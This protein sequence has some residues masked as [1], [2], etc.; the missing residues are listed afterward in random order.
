[1]TKQT[2]LRKPFSLALAAFISLAVLT[3]FG[4]ARPT[5]PGA[6]PV[7]ARVET[8][9]VPSS[10][11]AA[12]D[13]AIWVH[14]TDPALSTIIG[15]DKQKGIGVYD[16]GGRQLHFYRDGDLNNVDLRQ[17][18]GQNGERLDLV[19]AS[20]LDNET[21]VV[22]RVDA[23]TRGLVEMPGSPIQTTLGDVY[24]LCMYRSPRTGSVYAFAVGRD[25]NVEQWM[26]GPGPGGRVQGT[27][28][29]RF[30]VGDQSEGCVA[31]DELGHLYVAE[32]KAG[33]W[34]YGAEPSAGEARTSVERVGQG[35]LVPHVEGLTIYYGRDGQGYLI[36]SSQGSNAFVVYDRAGS[37]TF[38]MK[39]SLSDGTVDGV[40]DTD[41]ID[42]VSRPLGP[43]FPYG[44]FVA[45]DGR[46]TAPG[47]SGNQNF[48][49]VRWED[50]APII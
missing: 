32:E 42:V 44:L 40:N 5:D 48:K 47:N 33:I 13:P 19:V 37:N 11:D 16:L 25:G 38:R 34:K 9:P 14:P 39:F 18:V 2:T 12:D 8:E 10:G 26:L 20:N 22:Y 29:R 30:D 46:N 21:L 1:M 31:D 49:L 3:G 41:G 27:L 43:D 23:A 7:N 17:L 4:G 6:T 15:T 35:N 24:G 45:Q 28:Q 36:A 50:I